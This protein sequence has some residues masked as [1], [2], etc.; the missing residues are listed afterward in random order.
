MKAKASAV[1]S[2]QEKLFRWYLLIRT[3]VHGFWIMVNQLL[4]SDKL[5]RTGRLRRKVVIIGDEAA[6]GFGDWIICSETPGFAKYITSEI[7]QGEHVRFQWRAFSS[8]HIASTSDEWLP[9]HEGKPSFLG[10]LCRG[11][12][13]FEATF[14][15]GAR[16]A[17]ADAVVIMV[18]SHDTT[19]DPEATGRNVVAIAEKLAGMG[20]R[21][22]IN[23]V[24]TKGHLGAGRA[25]AG[26][27]LC[28][29]NQ[30]IRKFVTEAQKAQPHIY[31]GVDVE[32]YKRDELFA[33]DSVHLSSKG[34]R[35]IAKELYPLM[36][37]PLINI[38]WLFLR[39][40]LGEKLRE[41]GNPFMAAEVMRM[42][43]PPSTD[44][45]EKK[46]K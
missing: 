30:G 2:L 37:N 45:A 7:K 11:K 20:K 24:P 41:R 42:G 12:N 44:T 9:E 17:D 6:L 3:V 23:T 28:E 21:V 4:W 15:E 29:R 5:F 35:R 8:S 25:K 13:L 18:G 39:P 19:K 38:E 43:T 1:S 31:H 40:Q 27:V 14:G 22:W 36:K 34:Y 46:A 10:W 32:L 33:F 26:W 16:H